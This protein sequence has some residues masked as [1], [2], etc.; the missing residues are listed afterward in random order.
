MKHKNEITYIER[1]GILYP[2]PDLPE[3]T[4]YTTGKYGQMRPDFLN[5][6]RR[7]TYTTLLAAFKLNAH[8]AELDQEARSQIELLTL[9]I[10]KQRGIN[11]KLRATYQ[12]C[13]IQKT[14]N[15]KASAKKIILQEIVYQ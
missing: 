10:A 7:G 1:D 3:Q 9:Q 13:W 5:K 4:G 2:E 12:L 8:I 6:H 14:N 15:R 11:E